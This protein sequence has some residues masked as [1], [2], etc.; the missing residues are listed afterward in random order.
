MTIP[1]SPD[2]FEC[3]TNKECKLTMINRDENGAKNI[4]KAGLA[5][6][7]P[8]RFEKPANMKRSLKKVLLLVGDGGDDKRV[9][10]KRVESRDKK[11]KRTI[12]KKQ[13]KSIAYENNK[14]QKGR[15]RFNL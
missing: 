1:P 8:E 2:R 15:M 11:K 10:Q 4:M 9:K 6:H 3:C 12:R 5:E 14:L 13:R 7:Y